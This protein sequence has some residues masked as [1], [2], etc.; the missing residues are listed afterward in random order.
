MVESEFGVN[1]MRTWIHHA[2]FPLC[3]WWWWCNGV[4]DVFLAH[5]V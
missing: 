3:S 4:G 5:L 2:L 1:R